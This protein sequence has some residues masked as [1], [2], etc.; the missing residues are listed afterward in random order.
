MSV[1]GEEL[2]NQHV[3]ILSIYQID[4]Q[5]GQAS[6]QLCLGTRIAREVC[7]NQQRTIRSAP[8]LRLQSSR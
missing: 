2:S 5:K 1:R 3:E 6:E 4:F 8:R 7:F